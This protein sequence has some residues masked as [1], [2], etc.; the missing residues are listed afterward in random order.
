MPRQRLVEAVGAETDTD[1]LFRS[2]QDA[3]AIGSEI[4]P[5]APCEFAGLPQEHH[6]PSGRRKATMPR[7]LR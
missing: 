3:A 6:L 1:T 4:A 2:M 7:C 5:N